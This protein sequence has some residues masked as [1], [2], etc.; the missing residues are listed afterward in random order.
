MPAGLEMRRVR[1]LACDSEKAVERFK[2][3]WCVAVQGPKMQGLSRRSL[4]AH[5]PPR[6]VSPWRTLHCLSF[7]SCLATSRDLASPNLAGHW[8]SKCYMQET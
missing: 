4:E 7:G 3:W 6:H 2:G 8:V 5:P 1:C